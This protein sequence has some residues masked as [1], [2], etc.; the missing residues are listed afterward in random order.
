M[1]YDVRIYDLKMG[2]VPEYMKA[3]R[4]IGL[5][6]RNDHNVKLA[7]WYYTDIGPQNQVI[8]IWAYDSLAHME[9]A[10]VEVQA[11]PRWH[12]QYAPTVMPMVASSRNQIMIAAD[13]SPRPE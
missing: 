1:I 13:F 3:V 7:G 4:E 2:S 8:H 10:K 12:E 11:D 9:K 5:P 6:V